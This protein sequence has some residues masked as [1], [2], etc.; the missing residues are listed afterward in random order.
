MFLKHIK[1]S[2][3]STARQNNELESDDKRHTTSF[4]II[5]CSKKV[6]KCWEKSFL[7]RFVQSLSVTSKRGNKCQICL[8]I[9][10]VKSKILLMNQIGNPKLS[11]KENKKDLYDLLCQ[12]RRITRVQLYS[13]YIWVENWGHVSRMSKKEQSSGLWESSKIFKVGTEIYFFE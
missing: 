12:K 8:E 10:N 7:R 6:N 5:Q 11:Y 4:P 2:M 13:N 3:V 9:Y 1:K